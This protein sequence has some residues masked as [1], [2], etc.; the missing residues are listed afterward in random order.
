MTDR[1]SERWSPRRVR[2]VALARKVSPHTLRHSFA[3]HLLERG[4]DLRAIQELLGHASLS[5]TQ[6]YTHVNTRHILEIYSKTH[7]TGE[8]MLSIDSNQTGIEPTSSN[9]IGTPWLRPTRNW[10]RRSS[11]ETSSAFDQLV[12][13]WDRKIQGAVYR[14]IGSDEDARDLC[15]ETFLKAYRALGT[16]K[17]EARFSSWLYQIALNAC[18]DRLRRRRGHTE[19]S[20]DDME[21]RPE[22]RAADAGP[23]ALDL[24]RGQRPLPGRWRRRW[25][26]CRRS[27][28]R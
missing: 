11:R 23:T 8:V 19:V 1:S 27:S 21:D 3:T 5:T 16:F 12:R 14:I 17:K 10:S 7:P 9:N 13:R 25:R 26:P 24:D 28:G 22:R 4:A 6:R 18:R 15:Q 2:A 20:L